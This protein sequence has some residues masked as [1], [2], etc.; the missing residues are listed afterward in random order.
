ML[1]IDATSGGGAPQENV[2]VSAIS[3]D[4]TTGIESVTFTPSL[5]HLAGYSVQSAQ[6]QTLG[7]FYGNFVTRVGLDGQAA[8]SGN[9]TQTTLANNINQVRQSI[10]GININEETQN[11]VQYQN[12]YSAAARTINV[13]NQMMQTLINNLGVGS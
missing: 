10:S 12:A 1:T 3:V 4:P 5:S 9:Q 6:T 7:Q 2:V 11:L 8:I 13:I